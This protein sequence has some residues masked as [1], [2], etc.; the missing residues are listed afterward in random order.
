MTEDAEVKATDFRWCRFGLPLVLILLAGY[1]LFAWAR[2]D[3]HAASI[4]ATTRLTQEMEAESFAVLNAASSQDELREAVGRLGHVFSL[5]SGDWIAIRYRD[6]HAYNLPSSAVAVDSG[7]NWWV[8]Y[9]H[10]CGRFKTYRH[11]L[12]KAES[13]GE[14]ELRDLF[15]ENARGFPLLTKLSNADSLDEAHTTLCELG[16]QTAPRPLTSFKKLDGSF[17]RQD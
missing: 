12:N 1:G 11:W 9:E 15:N 7:G 3:Q 2:A 14:A 10:F 6:V 5:A 17:A 8:S 4:A 16:F 13:A